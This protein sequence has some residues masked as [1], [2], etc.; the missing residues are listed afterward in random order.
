[1]LDFGLARI[2]PR[3][4]E[5]GRR[6]GDDAGPLT[7]CRAPSCGTAAYMSPEQ[8]QGHDVDFRS[9]QF[10]LGRDA[11]RD[12]DRPPA[13]RAAARR[14]ARSP[15]SCATRRRPLDGSAL[16]PPL[17][18]LIA[19]C[20]AKNPGERY[21]STREIANELASLLEQ[22]EAP[23]GARARGELQRAARGAHLV[24]RA[25][26]RAAAIRE[27]LLLP[28]SSLVTL[29]GPGRHRQDPARD[30]RRRGDARQT[31]PGESAS[32]RSR[33][34]RDP[35]RVVPEIASGF[36]MRAAAGPQGALALGET[37]SRALARADAA[38][39][40]Q[41]RARGRRRARDHDAARRAP[42]G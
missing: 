29:T 13:V 11:L 10:S 1:M 17:Q 15:P 27:L 14:P 22:L 32:F 2:E 25:R 12:G 39:A 21:A 34:S 41:L 4:L 35:A 9:D 19:R 5:A 24:R 26:G 7:R 16:P 31:S 23:R 30:P 37:L 8:A 3:S 36:G 42:S 33:A 6:R 18:W 40:R 20:L 28:T 38:R